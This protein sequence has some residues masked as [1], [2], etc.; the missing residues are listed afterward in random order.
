MHPHDTTPL[1]DTA[2]A[3]EAFLIERFRGMTPSEKLEMVRRLNRSLIALST[4]GVRSRH[5]SIDERELALRVA[6]LR[7][8]RDLMIRAFGWDPEREGY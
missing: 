2:P 4:A 1:D 7:L 5:G 3:A 6:A 8:P